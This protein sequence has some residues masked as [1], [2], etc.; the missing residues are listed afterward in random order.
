MNSIPFWNRLSTRLG[1]LILLIVLVLAAAS[2]ILVVRGFNLLQQDAAQAIAALG[3]DGNSRFSEIISST[4]VNLLAVFLLTL[5]G[6]TVFSRSLLTEPINSLVD[7]TQEVAKGNLGLTLPVTSNSEL[8]MLATAFNEMSTNL[9]SRTQELVMANEALRRSEA[10]L[11][12]KIQE[13]TSELRALLE[14]SNGIALT[15]EDI[16]LIERIFD[17]LGAVIDFNLVRPSN[18]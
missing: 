15:T 6:A 11:E 10:D 7:A 3:V 9:A 14:L 2:A 12:Q 18:R 16:P 4:V 17:E 1:V 13:R 5:V 8:G